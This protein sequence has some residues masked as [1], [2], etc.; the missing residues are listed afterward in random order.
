MKKIISIDT[1]GQVHEML[2]LY[3]PEHPLVSVIPMDDLITKYNVI[4]ATYVLGFY[5]VSLKTGNCGV[6]TYGRNTYDFQEGTIVFTKP[7]QAISFSALD[8]AIGEGGWTLLFHPDL[9]RKS[10]LGKNIDN[11]TFFSYEIHEALHLSGREKSNLTDL[12][13]KVEGEYRQNIDQHTQKLI[14]TNIEL[15]LDYCTR[16][17]SRKFYVR[18]NMNQDIISRFNAF[19]VKY[20]SSAVATLLISIVLYINN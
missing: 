6:L 17:Y 4:E 18:T 10:E 1:I 7:K 16:Y 12:A 14:I 19:L 2:G 20:Y 8:G 3:E 5:Q 13:N 11:Y 15:L 9:I